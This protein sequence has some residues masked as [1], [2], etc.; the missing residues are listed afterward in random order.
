MATMVKNTSSND[1]RTS[2][3]GR[4]RT[5]KVTKAEFDGIMNILKNPP[6]PSD[7][8]KASAK[9]YMCHVTNNPDCNW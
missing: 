5:M 9:D 1:L 3:Q 7:R 2:T 6:P 8:M 4:G